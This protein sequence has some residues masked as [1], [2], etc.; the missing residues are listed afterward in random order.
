MWLGFLPI[1]HI[2]ETKMIAVSV[3][4]D[5]FEEYLGDESSVVSRGDFRLRSERSTS[6]GSQKIICLF[7]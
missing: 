1:N 6:K 5:Y 7:S 3:R 4:R 2:L